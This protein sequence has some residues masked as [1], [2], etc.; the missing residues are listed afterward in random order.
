MSP[1]YD[2]DDYESEHDCENEQQTE[3]EDFMHSYG[4]CPGDPDDIAEG[5]AIQDALDEYD[6]QQK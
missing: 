5:E 2:S 1:P 3:Y 6:A 4:L